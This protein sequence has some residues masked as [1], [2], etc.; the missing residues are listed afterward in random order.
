MFSEPAMEADWEMFRQAG[1]R[2]NEG[3]AA[4][5][6]ANDAEALA[7]LREHGVR[8]GQHLA[9]MINMMDPEVVILGEEAMRFGPALTDAIKSSLQEATL[10][11]LPEIAI[12]WTND[13]WSR[14]AAALAIQSFFDF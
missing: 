11:E 10:G 9:G 7:F 12:D 6:V 2:P 13:I 4:A 14:A 8:I 5:A 1:I 3:L